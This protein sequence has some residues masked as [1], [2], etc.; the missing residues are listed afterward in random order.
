T[1]RSTRRVVH[2]LLGLRLNDLHNE[3]YH[4]ARTVEFSALLTCIIGKL[5]DKV[6]VGIAQQI[7]GYQTVVA[8]RVHIK[9]SQE[10][11]QNL[12]RQFL[13]IAKLGGSHHTLQRSVLPLNG[14]KGF[15]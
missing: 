14:C 1:A 11:L 10:S 15:V 9:M 13:L 5:L 8:Q 7:A 12:I 6:F 2:L 4:A 3:L